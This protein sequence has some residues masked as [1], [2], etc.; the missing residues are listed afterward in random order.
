MATTYC[1]GTHNWQGK[2]SRPLITVAS[3]HFFVDH[4]MP[5]L[6]VK[7]LCIDGGGIASAVSL[8]QAGS[9]PSMANSL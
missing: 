2:F 7:P 6:K 4:T 8:P 3:F 9:P 5:L 1:T